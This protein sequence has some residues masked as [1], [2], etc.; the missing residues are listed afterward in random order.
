[1]VPKQ[2]IL[3]IVFALAVAGA[4]GALMFWPQGPEDDPAVHF[5]PHAPN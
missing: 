5:D 4:A 1:M 3:A 2:I